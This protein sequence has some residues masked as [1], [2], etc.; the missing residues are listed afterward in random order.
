MFSRHKVQNIRH[1]VQY[2]VYAHAHYDIY[3]HVQF[4]V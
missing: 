3:L 2:T 1:C 4:N